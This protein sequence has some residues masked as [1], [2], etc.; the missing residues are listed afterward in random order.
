[1]IFHSQN[2]R[3]EEGESTNSLEA[4]VA[5]STVVVMMTICGPR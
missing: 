1:M 3:E 5:W 2:R 4:W